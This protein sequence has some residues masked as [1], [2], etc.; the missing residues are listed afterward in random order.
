MADAKKESLWARYQTL[1]VERPF[2]MHLVQSATITAAGSSLAQLCTK[3]AVLARPL[4]EQVLLSLFFIAPVVSAW[5]RLTPWP[6][7]PRAPERVLP[8]A[9]V[10]EARTSRA[11]EAGLVGGADPSEAED[12]LAQVL[13]C[14]AE[15]VD[16][17]L[18]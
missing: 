11:V 5:S 10:H 15:R 12:E 14:A 6:L 3:G 13:G 2:S 9:G 8:I 4:L 16:V 17:A 1:L 18:D 7:W